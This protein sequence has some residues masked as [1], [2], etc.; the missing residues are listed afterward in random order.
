MALDSGL[1][2]TSKRRYFEP[3]TPAD[4][5]RLTH[6][7]ARWRTQ[8]RHTIHAHSTVRLIHQTDTK[9]FYKSFFE[10]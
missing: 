9:S 5:E 7:Y 2:P 4:T 3:K 10:S 8:G 1:D 6:E